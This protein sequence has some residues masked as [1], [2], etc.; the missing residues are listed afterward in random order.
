MDQNVAKTPPLTDSPAASKNE[1]LKQLAESAGG[2]GS[3][4][5]QLAANPFFTAGFGLAGL[6]AAVRLGQ[7]GLRRGTE[8]L[9]R[10]LL[11]D[12]EITRHDQ[13]YPWVLD[14]MTRQYQQ[15]LSVSS[16]NT[17]VG[18][19]ESLIRRFTPGLHHLQ[20]RTDSMKIP[21]GGSQTH[22]A[23]VPGNGKHILRFQNAFIAVNRERVGKSFDS[24]GQPFETITLTTLYA[25]RHVFE[26]IFEEAHA[27]SQQS[28]EGKTV[29]YTRGQTSWVP[30]GEAKRK[31]PFES[32]VLAEGLAENIKSDVKEFLDARTWYLD[33]GIPYR[34]GYLLYGPPGTGKT[35]FVQAIAGALDFNIAM[36]SLSQRGLTDDLLNHMLLNLPPRTFVLLEDADA[37]FNNR[38]QRQEDGYSGATVTF[39]GLL[40]ALDGVASAEE[41]VVFMTTNHIERLDDALI[42]PGR[43]D[44]TVRLGEA[45]QWQMEQMWDRFYAQFDT[46]GKGRALFIERAKQYELVNA[47]STAALQG[48][49]LYN[50]NDPQGAIDTLGQLVM[51]KIG[52]GGEAQPP[53]A[54]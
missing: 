9:K 46:D 5:S 29:V 1:A 52:S 18:R 7:Q 54:G 34:R 41:R 47:V 45:S 8:L 31:R 15:Q 38:M 2:D 27:F 36:L 48:L 50:K 11:V 3:I 14:W 51:A 42:R 6:G 44:M 26:Q 21:G 25:H 17:Q 10:R 12:I 4:F 32:V 16:G 13:S 35:S 37:A 43:V 39:S 23:L 24:S 49:F 53:K 20:I 19:I 30:L 28:V 40:N 33:R 22:F